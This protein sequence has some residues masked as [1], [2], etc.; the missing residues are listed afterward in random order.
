MQIIITQDI[1]DALKSMGHVPDELRARFDAI[2]KTDGG[3]ALK[4]SDDES[5]ELAELMQWHMRTDPATGKPTAQSAP[6]GRLIA[7]IDEAQ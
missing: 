2:T 7:L 3:Y 6:F 4:L 5:V 1:V